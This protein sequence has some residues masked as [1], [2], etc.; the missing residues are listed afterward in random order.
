MTTAGG[1]CAGFLM[2]RWDVWVPPAAFVLLI[3]A[4]TLPPLIPVKVL[5][6]VR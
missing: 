2:L 1:R 5:C 4:F 6:F 3:A